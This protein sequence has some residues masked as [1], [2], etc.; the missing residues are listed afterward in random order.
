MSQPDLVSL[1][2]RATALVFPSLFG[3]ENFPPLEAFALEC[4]VVAGR[5]PGAEEQMGEAAILVDPTNHELWSDAV[6]SILQD[7][8][9]RATLIARGKK[10]APGLWADGVC[11]RTDS[12]V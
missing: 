7:R 1:Y 5:I 2:Q 12:V 9:L 10:R 11:S 8:E 4:P 3:P 6:V